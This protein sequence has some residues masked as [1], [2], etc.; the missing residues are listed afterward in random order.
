V[1]NAATTSVAPRAEAL[2]CLL[3]LVIWKLLSL[4]PPPK[5]VANTIRSRFGAA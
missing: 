5:S 4:D 1:S 3:F 2:I